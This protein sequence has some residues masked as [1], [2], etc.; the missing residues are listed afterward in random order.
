MNTTKCMFLK[1]I[2][3]IPL[4]TYKTVCFVRVENPVIYKLKDEYIFEG[5]QTNSSGLTTRVSN[6]LDPKF[7]KYK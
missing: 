4:M 3:T 1:G 6:T 7:F 5:T 2:H